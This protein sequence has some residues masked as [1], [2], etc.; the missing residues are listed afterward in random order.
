MNELFLNYKAVSY[1]KKTNSFKGIKKIDSIRIND[2]LFLDKEFNILKENFSNF[3]NNKKYQHCLLTGA[4]GCGKTSLVKAVFNEFEH[5]NLRIIE[6]FKDDLNDLRYIIDD[7]QELDYKF[8]IF[9]DDLSFD[10]ND[11]AY[12]I[13]KPIIDGGIEILSDNIMFIVSSNY[14]NILKNSNTNYQDADFNNE[15]D[16]KFSLKERFG[17]WLT[18]Y[19][20]NQEQYLKIIKS[21]FKDLQNQTKL[22]EEA[23]KFSNLRAS[24][25]GRTAKQFCEIFKDYL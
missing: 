14:N 23:I 15:M 1:R 17:I 8:I 21:H 20:L 19:S 11:S 6:I 13:L 7:L 5:T 12:K 9:L 10:I 3:L 18:F 25:S 2:L 22:I 16:D 4:K 24:K